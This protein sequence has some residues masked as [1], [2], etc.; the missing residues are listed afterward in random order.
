MLTP[1][2]T[3]ERTTMVLL[4][5]NVLKD[6]SRVGSWEVLLLCQQVPTALGLSPNKLL[7]RQ[8]LWF[9]ISR[10]Q[11]LTVGHRGM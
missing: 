2:L 3:T 10:L 6:D 4:S 7:L 11:R 5:W 1:M 9:K 8:E